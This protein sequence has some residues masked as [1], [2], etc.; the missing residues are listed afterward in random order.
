M[1]AQG[2][3]HSG[4]QRG[5]ALEQSDIGADDAVAQAGLQAAQLRQVR[6][7]VLP[8]SRMNAAD[9]TRTDDANP[10]PRRGDDRGGDRGAANPRV[11]RCRREVPV[12]D[13]DGAGS[14]RERFTF[15][16]REANSQRTI[17]DGDYSWDD[18]LLLAGLPLALDGL[19]GGRSGQAMGDDR[20]LE[21]HDRLARL[22]RTVNVRRNR[23]RGHG[24]ILRGYIHCACGRSRTG[25]GARLRTVWRKPWGFESLRPHN[26]TAPWRREPA[27]PSTR[28]IP[29]QTTTVIARAPTTPSRFGCRP[30]Q[31]PPV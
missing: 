19:D 16:D 23:Q 31:L 17:E 22:K 18:V 25:T 20:R 21:R 2:L 30:D 4:G 26:P 7:D 15:L 3:R 24:R 5:I 12:R 27:Y 10:G 8:V 29:T 9:T 13:L 28:A 11:D 14:A 6:G 1:V